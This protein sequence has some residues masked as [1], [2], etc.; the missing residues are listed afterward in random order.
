MKVS[1]RI[2]CSLLGLSLWLLT[3]RAFA[4]VETHLVSDDVR[5]EVERS[6][7][8]I[9]DHAITMRIQGGPLRS[10]DL[11]AAD[12]EVTPL[13]DSTVISAQTEGILGLPIPLQVTPGPDGALRINIESPRGVSRGIFLFHVRYRKNLLAGDNVRRDGAMLRIRWAGPTWQE[14]LD[15]ARCTFIVPSGPTEPRPP[16]VG[17]GDHDEGDDVDE[18][19]MFLSQVK[20]SAD[21]DEVELIRPHVARSEVVTWSIR[22]DPRVLGEIND[23]RLRPAAPPLPPHVIPPEERAAYAALAGALL[24]GFSVLVG[25]KARQ[26]KR[27]AQGIA[28]VRTLIPLPTALR[29]LLS[30]P[31]LTGGVALQLHWDDPWWG[32]LLVLLA[33]ALTWY[34]QPVWI[35]HARGPGRWLPV[36]DK[37]AF[38]RPVGVK[39][40]WLDTTT[41]TGQVLFGLALAGVVGLAYAASRASTY[42]AYLVAL[43][44]AVLF[45]LFGT[46]RLGDLPNPALSG[47]APILRRIAEKLRRR[48]GLRVIAWGRLPEGTDQFDEL[49]LLCAPKIPIRGFTGIEVG[50]VGVGGIGGSIYLPE[51]L[52][53]VIDASPCHEAFLKLLPGSRFIRGRK[54]DERV[55]SLR[56]RLPTVAMTA[57]L[58]ARLIEHAF[59]VNP[60]SIRRSSGEGHRFAGAS[61]NCANA[62]K[63]VKRSSGR[64]ERASNGGTTASPFHAM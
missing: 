14:G 3:S 24:L 55:T 56:P 51:V 48:S 49:R 46:G 31:A 4:W 39:D 45:P 37:E 20:R 19:G 16:G 29:T 11:A 62:G 36:G 2:A 5:V 52:V 42:G 64:P 38:A 35:R 58:A 43:D 8:A 61:A 13:G 63:A 10:F 18:G 21:H 60:A 27:H 23:P 32:T 41:R 1:R 54:A 7:G 25:C 30:G 6:G 44:S 12:A 33:M 28:R 17:A 15:N 59:E 26:V 50:L 9:I 34:L 47:P 57:A 22:V 40:A 53:R